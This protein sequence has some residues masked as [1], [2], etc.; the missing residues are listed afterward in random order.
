MKLSNFKLT[1]SPSTICFKT[2]GFSDL[3]WLNVNWLQ[4]TIK[5]NPLIWFASSSISFSKVKSI[6]LY[7]EFNWYRPIS[8]FAAN[9]TIILLPFWSQFGKTLGRPSYNEALI[10][11]SEAM[12]FLKILGL[13]WRN[14]KYLASNLKASTETNF[15]ARRNLSM[16]ASS[17]LRK[18]EIKKI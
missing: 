14:S 1:W 5:T 7:I 18:A 2:F 8:Q 11:G 13:F 3:D 16:K 4:S 17:V 6:A 9:R 12:K 10:S 15:L